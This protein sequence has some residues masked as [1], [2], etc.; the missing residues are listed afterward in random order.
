MK[1]Q[2]GAL[3]LT[4]GGLI[5]LGVLAWQ[6]PVWAL[7]TLGAMLGGAGAVW[8]WHAGHEPEITPATALPEPDA[9]PQDVRLQEIIAGNAL[10]ETT[11]ESMREVMLAVD[12]NHRIIASNRAA[13]ALFRQTEEAMTHRRLAELTR[14]LDVQKAFQTALAG[15]RAEAEIELTPRQETRIFALR[16]SPLRFR[17][18]A[19]QTGAVGIFFDITKL[20]RLEKVRQEFL[21]NVSHELRTPLTAIL[22]LVETLEDGALDDPEHNRRFLAIIRRNAERMRLLM[23]DILEL[24]TIEAGKINLERH[25][26]ALGELVDAICDT[27]AVRAEERQVTLQ[28]EVAADIVVYADARRLEQMLTNL[29]DN[30]VKFTGAGGFVTITHRLEDGYDCI[31]VKDTGPGIAPEHLPRLFERFYRVDRARSRDLGGTGLGLAIVKHLARAHGG[32][33]CVNSQLGHGASFTI[34]LPQV[35]AATGGGQ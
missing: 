34:K 7:V 27:L 31:S 3:L 5:A 29:L 12:A 11:M 22:A 1:P 17:R 28:Q 2:T 8:L 23:N 26:V 19:P 9:T 21:S 24:S 6:W 15:T 16:V 35:K 10:L 25:E 4:G 32:E 20:E 13:R 14:D 18:T 30:A 33:A